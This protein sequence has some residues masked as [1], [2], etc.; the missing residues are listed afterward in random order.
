[1]VICYISIHHVYDDWII[2]SIILLS[3]KC[4]FNGNTFLVHV[5]VYRAAVECKR[6]EF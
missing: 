1:M 5:Y 3:I 4:D 2:V 6:Q